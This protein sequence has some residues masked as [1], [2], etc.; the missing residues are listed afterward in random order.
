[1]FSE[2]LKVYQAQPFVKYLFSKNLIIPILSGYYKDCAY[3]C[4]PVTL[5]QCFLTRV[6]PVQSRG[7]ARLQFKAGFK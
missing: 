5:D 2:N 1:M 3:L 7:S 4:R 6:P